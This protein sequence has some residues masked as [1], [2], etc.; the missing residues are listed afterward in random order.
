MLGHVLA[1]EG[2][3]VKKADSIPCPHRA[4]PLGRGGGGESNRACPTLA[5]DKAGRRGY[6]YKNGVR[7]DLPMC[8]KSTIRMSFL[9]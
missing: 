5:S 3:G 2:T 4:A 7:E 9:Q 6:S 1:T 8:G